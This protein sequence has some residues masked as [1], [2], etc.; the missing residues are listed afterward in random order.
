MCLGRKLMRRVWVWVTP[1]NAFPSALLK[2][3]PHIVKAALTVSVSV[4][5]RAISDLLFMSCCKT[6]IF[7]R[8]LLN[9]VAR[10]LPP[11]TIN[12]HLCVFYRK[13]LFLYV[14]QGVSYDKRPPWRAVEADRSPWRRLGQ[15]VSSVY[16]KV[17]YQSWANPNFFAFCCGTQLLNAESINMLR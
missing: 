10:T 17:Y 11:G 14:V 15:R 1:H 3:L 12:C 2:T 5:E 4:A 8:H 16:Y 7:P 9:N 6:F 13:W